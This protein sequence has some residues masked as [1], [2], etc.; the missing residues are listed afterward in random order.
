MQPLNAI[1]SYQQE[2][3]D[4]V[5]MVTEHLRELSADAVEALKTRC[6][7]YLSFRNDVDIFLRAFFSE[8]CTQK[9]YRSRLSACCQKEGIIT[10]FADVVINAL[11]SS[12]DDLNTLLSVLYASG[13]GSKCVY[14][15]ADGCLWR[16]KPIGCEMFLCDAAAASVFS[17]NPE[18]TGQWESLKMRKQY[19][20]WPDHQVLFDVIEE[21]FMASGCSSSLMYFHNSPGLLRVK[22]LAGLLPITAP[23]RP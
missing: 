15:G 4:A 14:L 21:I 3:Y 18:I 19:F 5:S 11:F 13:A 6:A 20:T 8:T 22:K 17:R 16:I 12:P 1:S 2:Q 9:C 23:C 10:F 7:E